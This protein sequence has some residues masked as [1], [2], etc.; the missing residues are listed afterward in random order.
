MISLKASRTTQIQMELETYER[1]QVVQRRCRL[2]H[3]PNQEIQLNLGLSIVPL[4]QRQAHAFV[5]RT[6][7][8]LQ[9]PRGD[10]IRVGL[11]RDGVLV[12]V[13]VAGRPSSRHQQDGAT[14]EITRVAVISGVDNGCSKIYAALRRAASNLG[15]KRVITYTRADETGVSLRAAGFR[16]DGVSSGGSWSRRRRPRA[17][18]ENGGPKVRWAWP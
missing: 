10:V 7:R 18:P 2:P 5:D 8:H 15:Y 17:A 6:H 12:G 1:S 3:A 4:S 9:S 16:E 14:L 11:T 13:G